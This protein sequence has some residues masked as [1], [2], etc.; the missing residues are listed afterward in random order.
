MKA[1]S[2]NPAV[3]LTSTIMGLLHLLHR[4]QRSSRPPILVMAVVLRK[5]MKVKLLLLQSTGRPAF[6]KHG[7]L[8]RGVAG[9][10]GLF[11][12]ARNKTCTSLREKILTDDSWQ[13]IRTSSNTEHLCKTVAFPSM[14]V[15][16]AGSIVRGA[17]AILHD[18]LG[19][20]QR[21]GG[22]VLIGATEVAVALSCE[23]EAKLQYG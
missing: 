5:H 13:W 11:T 19:C 9:A 15:V 1:R 17:A 22:R 10:F 20:A 16:M 4:C 21:S 8:G 7:G 14:L 18:I 6:R 3:N 23:N 12:V 2:F